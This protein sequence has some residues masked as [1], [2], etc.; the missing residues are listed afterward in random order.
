MAAHPDRFERRRRDGRVVDG[1]GDLHLEHVWFPEDSE[2]PIFIDCIEF[3][4]R[5]RQIDGASEVAFLAMDLAHR[6]ERGLADRFLRHYA[7]ERDDYSL[8]PV[9]DYFTSY[10]AAVRSKVAAIASSDAEIPVPE[11]RAAQARASV[12]LDLAIE[13]L[14]GRDGRVLERATAIVASGRVAVLDAT[15]SRGAQRAA[16][17]DFARARDVPFLVLETRCSRGVVQ[18]RLAERERVGGDPSDAG[19]D[20]Y[21]ESVARFAAVESPER[22]SHI[23]IET[24]SPEWRRT[25]RTRLQRWQAALRP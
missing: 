4:D 21:D 23:V 7:R 18:E 24:D 10:R 2:G 8:Y 22:G 6:G 19:P 11:Q 17:E 16:A 15:F 5:L 12:D 13:S 9:V 14:A 3:S 1:H 25:L 20:F